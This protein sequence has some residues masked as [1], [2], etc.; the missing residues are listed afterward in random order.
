MIGAMSEP[1]PHVGLTE[2][3]AMFNIT[4][5]RAHTIAAGE[6]F[7]APIAETKAGRTWRRADVE[8][9]AATWPRTRGRP[10]KNPKPPTD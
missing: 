1:T 3:A 4:R 2:I 8:K 7:P 6:T 5:Q 10:R 9:W